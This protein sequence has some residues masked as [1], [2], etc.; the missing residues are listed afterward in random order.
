MTL[1]IGG[2]CDYEGVFSGNLAVAKY[3]AGTFTAGGASTNIGPVAVYD[4]VLRVTGSFTVT[5]YT[6]AGYGSPQIVLPGDPTYL[7]GE[8]VFANGNPCSPAVCGSLTLNASS[9]ETGG[10]W[11]NAVVQA[12]NSSGLWIA[13]QSCYVMS[14]F[15]ANFGRDSQIIDSA[16][17]PVRLDAAFLV[18]T[19]D[20]I[21]DA[22]ENLHN[23]TQV[24]NLSS[25]EAQN[26]AINADTQ[27]IAMAHQHRRMSLL[28]LLLLTAGLQR[29]VDRELRL[30]QPVDRQRQRPAV[31]H[32]GHQPPD[33]AARP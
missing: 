25:L 5:P 20:D 23:G 22:V 9:V 31:R 8:P 29:R 27:I 15:Y 4:G 2:Y 26:P 10:D 11:A 30:R 16:D 12:V 14:H 24:F 6:V 13:G 7:M 32:A 1:N 18:G 19:A 28:L 21:I 17:T 33:E 3:G